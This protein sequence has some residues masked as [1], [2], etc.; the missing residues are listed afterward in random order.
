[1]TMSI[2]SIFCFQGFCAWIIIL[3]SLISS[4]YFLY[5]FFK[6]LPYYNSAV[7]NVFGAMLGVY[8]WISLNGLLMEL[9]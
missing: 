4:S 9:Y 2:I 3:I 1:M 5:N 8:F 6:F 7:S